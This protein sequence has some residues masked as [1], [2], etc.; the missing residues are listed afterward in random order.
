MNFYINQ[1]AQGGKQ[2]Q[3]TIQASSAS[4]AHAAP[5]RMG[6]GA[7]MSSASAS[8]MMS[9]SH[10]ASQSSSSSVTTEQVSGGGMVGAQAMM[11]SGMFGTGASNSRAEDNLHVVS[12]GGGSE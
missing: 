12:G 11:N 10:S 4:Q 9:G 5:P 7:G 8:S 1:R 6:G 3:E 2:V